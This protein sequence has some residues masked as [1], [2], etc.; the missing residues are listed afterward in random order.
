MEVPVLSI[1]SHST[2]CFLDW[3]IG[4]DMSKYEKEENLNLIILSKI[5][6]VFTIAVKFGGWSRKVKKKLKN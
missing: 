5:F 2:A 6:G 1:S 4:F 3:R